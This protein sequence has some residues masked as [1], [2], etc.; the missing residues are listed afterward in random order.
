M[1]GSSL[2]YGSEKTYDPWPRRDLTIRDSYAHTRVHT[3]S[4]VPRISS[5]HREKVG[6]RKE[7]KESKGRLLATHC[8]AVDGKKRSPAICTRER[9]SPSPGRRTAVVHL[10]TASR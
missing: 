7:E 6:R 5:A 2:S 10:R 3:R 4:F 9:F 8:S 1:R